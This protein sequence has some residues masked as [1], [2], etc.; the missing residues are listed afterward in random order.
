MEGVLF[1]QK[2]ISIVEGGGSGGVGGVGGWMGG[3]MKG[4]VGGV[5]E[6]ARGETVRWVRPELN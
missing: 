5:G 4:E 2:S 1:A 6:G 3:W